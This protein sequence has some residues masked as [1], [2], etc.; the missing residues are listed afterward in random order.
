MNKL[1]LVTGG[2]RGIGAAIA[3]GAAAQGWDVALT[4]LRDLDS[5]AAVAADVRALGREAWVFQADVSQEADVLRVFSALEAAVGP[6]GQRLQGLVN[7]AG[8]VDS[9]QRVQDMS[10]DRW[11]R[12]FAVNVEGTFLCAR[13]AVRHMSTAR[14]GRGGSIVNVT[15]AA[16]RI[17]SPAQYVDYAASKAAV[18]TFSIGLGKEVA[19]EGIRVNAVRP[20]IID[21]EIHASGGQPDKAWASAS[22]IP[23]QRPGTPQEVADAVL[24]LLSPQSSYATASILEVTGGR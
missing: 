2:S 13:E 12:M 16:A 19:A 14:G 17:G 8:I 24:W 18:D 4:A 20:G 11:R 23:L 7:N 3:R 10:L 1:V 5:A 6:L 15:S 22:A 21:T 9:V